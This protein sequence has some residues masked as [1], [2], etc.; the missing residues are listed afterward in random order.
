MKNHEKTF[1][2]FFWGGGVFT[3]DQIFVL[4]FANLMSDTNSS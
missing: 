4:V 2:L 3:T 1:L